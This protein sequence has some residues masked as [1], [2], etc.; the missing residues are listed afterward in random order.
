MT[1]PFQIA[2]DG[3]FDVLPGLHL[4]VSVA[5]YS[6]NFGSESYLTGGLPRAEYL[7]RLTDGPY[8]TSSQPS[9]QAWLDA[10]RDAASRGAP[11]ILAV[12]I[13][14]GLSGSINAAQQAQ[15]LFSEESPVPVRIFDTRTLSLGQTFMLYALSSAAQRGESV[16]TAIRWAEQVREET[17]FCF[18]METLDYLQRG[19][20]IGRV[21]ATLGGLLN[22][23]PIVTVQ[24]PEGIYTTAAK[25]RG[26]KAALRE[27]GALVTR[28]FG[29]GTPLRL[30]LMSSSD[31]EDVQSVRQDI[32][33]RHPL[34]WEGYADVNEALLVHT[35]PRA[36]GLVAAPR[37]WPWER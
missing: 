2:T 16:D 19:G 6:V 1:Q 21:T 4:P 29:E 8:P 33:S 11:Q 22:L 36:V 18:T 25:V 28:R 12:T 17:A 20:R 34:L 7:R 27:L 9:P 32:A 3:G 26:Y 13:S 37:T 30:G 35:G 14:G 10:L 31:S 23:K 15:Q 5:P 24:Q